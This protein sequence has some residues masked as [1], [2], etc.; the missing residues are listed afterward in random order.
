MQFTPEEYGIVMNSRFLLVKSALLEKV[1]N[2]LDALAQVYSTYP[3]Q[4]IATRPPKISKGENYRGLP[5]MVLDYPAVFAKDDIIAIRT[6]FWWGHFFSITLHLQGS[7]KQQYAQVVKANLK[8]L[9]PQ[10]MYI[11]C[12][13]TP[14]EYHYAEDNY[15]L[16]S[17]LTAV[18]VDNI[19]NA[20]PFIKLSM[21]LP[22]PDYDKLQLFM[23]ESYKELTGLL[24]LH[25]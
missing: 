8:K 20:K 24:K 7:Y 10:N 11:A 12:G 6:M 4:S 5:Y 25:A 23:E 19:I 14:W 2:Q 15:C 3:F 1:K 16:V 9:K 21:Q 22:L 18:E 17:M 13:E